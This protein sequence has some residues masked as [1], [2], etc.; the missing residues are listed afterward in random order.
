MNREER[1]ERNARK[2]ELDAHIEDAGIINV[3]RSIHL[4]RM[5]MM[6][7]RKRGELALGSY[8]RRQEGWSKDKSESERKAIATRVAALMANGAD[9]GRHHNIIMSSRAG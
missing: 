8:L 2:R 5:F 3:I 4:E 6:D 9:L 1:Q 7:Q